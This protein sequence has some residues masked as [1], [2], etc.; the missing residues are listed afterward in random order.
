MKFIQHYSSSRSNLYEVVGGGNSPRRLLLECGIRWAKIQQAINFK[1]NGIDGCLLTHEHKDHSKAAQDVMT[2]GINVFSSF[3]TFEAL[4]LRGQRRAISVQE[5]QTFRA[6]EAFAAVPFFIRHD[7]ADPYGYLIHEVGTEEYLFFAP[8]SGFIEQDF[9]VLHKE[10][11]EVRRIQFTI[12]AIECSYDKA[13]LQKRVKEK[14]INYAL[15][16]RLLNSHA[17]KET[18]MAYLKN[19]C[20]L[21]RCREIHLL[22][23]SADNLNK[24]ATVKEFQKKLFIDIFIKGVKS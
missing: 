8:D 22:H 12:I 20:D 5:Y 7:G 6:G 9:K 18:T 3:K 23:T 15:A 14:T 16:K 13:I 11:E 24:R 1:L 4:N 21:T 2:A 10:E 19:Y 17:E